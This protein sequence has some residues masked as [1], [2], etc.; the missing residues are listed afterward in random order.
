MDAITW[1]ANIDSNKNQFTD[2][3]RITTTQI[4]DSFMA[5]ENIMK[6]PKNFEGI[7][8][9]SMQVEIIE[10]NKKKQYQKQQDLEMKINDEVQDDNIQEFK[11][12]INSLLNDPNAVKQEIDEIQKRWFIHFEECIR[13]KRIQCITEKDAYEVF[14]SMNLNIHNLLDKFTIKGHLRDGIVFFLIDDN[15]MFK[16]LLENGM[17]DEMQR[18]ITISSKVTTGEITQHLLPLISK[19]QQFVNYHKAEI[20]RKGAQQEK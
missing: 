7:E 5:N 19:Y 16:E 2:K 6:R 9:E 1:F 10:I 17:N 11:A 12:S 15:Q 8:L 20:Q 4:A 3:L 14:T 13:M 18:K